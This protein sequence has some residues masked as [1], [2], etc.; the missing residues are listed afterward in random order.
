M[1]KGNR[2]NGGKSG[3]GTYQQIIN[4][5]PPHKIYVSAFAGKDGV[6]RNMIFPQLTVINDIDPNVLM[7]WKQYFKDKPEF[8]VTE[9]FIQSS[10]FYYPSD[11]KQVILRNND[12]LHIIDRFKNSPDTIIYCDPPYPMQTRKGKKQLYAFEFADRQQHINL[13]SIIVDCNC[14]VIA[15]TYK[16]ELYNSWLLQPMLSRRNW[17]THSFNSTTHAGTAVET[18]YFN[19]NQPEILHDFRYLGKDFRER[20][21]IK[22]KI[23]RWKNKLQR[24][25]AQ[26]R[27]AILSATVQD[28]NSTINTII[29]L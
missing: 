1:R 18:I 21:D 11:K 10:L 14:N 26:E 15:S 13:L 23:Q 8:E 24:L 12:A 7:W 3:S 6:L 9:D 22:R 4:H 20:Q 17:Q 25:P 16:N 28:Y 5:I 2:Y 19:Y 29:K 27:C